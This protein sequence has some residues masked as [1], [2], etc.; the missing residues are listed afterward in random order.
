[1]CQR[2]PC[3][4]LHQRESHWDVLHYVYILCRAHTYDHATSKGYITITNVTPDKT[5][6]KALCQIYLQIQSRHHGYSLVAYYDSL[7][8]HPAPSRMLKCY[9]VIINHHVTYIL[10]LG[11]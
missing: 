2:T 10:G 7:C 6:R 11:V 4:A 1:M 5:D 8:C 3:H 9:L